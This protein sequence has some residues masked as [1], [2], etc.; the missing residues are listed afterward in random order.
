MEPL[1][2]DLE[3]IARGPRSA[4]P[5]SRLNFL[6]IFPIL[7]FLLILTFIGA[8]IFQWDIS[9]LIDSLVGL[10]LL[11]FVAF[12]GMMFWA[13]APRTNES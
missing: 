4:T 9:D 13:L 12:I 2:S 7:G 11:L 8:A 3:Y 6:L 10:L 1:D 5:G